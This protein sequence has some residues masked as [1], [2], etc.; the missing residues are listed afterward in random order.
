L[1]PLEAGAES[2]DVREIFAR[3]SAEARR[4]VPL[5]FDVPETPGNVAVPLP[6]RLAIEEEAFV[7]S[8]V[9]IGAGRSTITGLLRL[10][11]DEPACPVEYESQL[12]FH[13]LVAAKA[14]VHAGRRSLARWSARRTD[15]LLHRIRGGEYFCHAV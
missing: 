9:R 2:L 4:I 15:F 7:L 3:I 6:L 1:E 13:R 14:C 8:D 5:D 11:G 12:L 10:A